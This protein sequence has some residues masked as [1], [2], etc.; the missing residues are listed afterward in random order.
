MAYTAS[1]DAV[2]S[3]DRSYV[4]WSAIISGAFLATAYAFTLLTFGAAAGLS[5]FSP[6]AYEGASV[7][8]MIVAVALWTI[9]VQV[10]AFALGG[11]VAGRM[12]PRMH[13]A[14][15]HEAEVRDGVH[16][17]LVWAV[18]VLVGGMIAVAATGS[19]L[20]IG[21][22]A[23]TSLD[24]GV[25]KNALGATQLSANALAD[26]LLRPTDATATGA[27]DRV[28]SEVSR[29]VTPATTGA[30]LG[31][32]DQ[33]YLT[34]VV[35]S[36][37]GLT[38]A[39]ASKRVE[40]AMTQAATA[41]EKARKAA[42]I[43]GFIVAVSLLVSAAAAWWAADF[44]GDHRD[45]GVDYS[46]F[47]RWK[48]AAGKVVPASG[49][50]D[51]LT[52]IKGIGPA[53]QEQLRDMNITTFQQIARFSQD[54]VDRVSEALSFPGQIEREDWVGQAQE[55]IKGKSPT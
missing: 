19:V 51:D 32:E 39:E 6:F 55:L 16:G 17:L 8:I 21:S 52:E 18:G 54:D 26:A 13:D 38:P 53:I 31:D 47:M 41:A 12:R 42:I 25:A 45:R 40:S 7:T 23:I 30:T 15:E 37:T 14:T 43:I 27:D 1:A 36:Q 50:P 33:A 20:G 28:R 46:R 48:P 29:L 2:S 5:L 11:Y 10:S 3:V 24:T 35:A 4:N 34:R 9:W 22:K 49:R 44:G